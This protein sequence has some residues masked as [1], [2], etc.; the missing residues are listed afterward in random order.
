MARRG[1]PDEWSFLSAAER[2]SFVDRNDGLLQRSRSCT[3]CVKQAISERS[4]RYCKNFNITA[5]VR[6]RRDA[7]RREG[8]R[9]LASA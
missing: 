3:V 2:F 6:H 9:L 7:P 4:C 5:P 8:K 1:G